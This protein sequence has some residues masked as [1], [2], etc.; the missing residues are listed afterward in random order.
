MYR[1]PPFI[2]ALCPLFLWA[3]HTVTGTLIDCLE[4][5]AVLYLTRTARW[6]PARVCVWVPDGAVR[7]LLFFSVF[8]F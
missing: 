6:A 1:Q 2:F 4:I 8:S 7:G 5:L 3:L